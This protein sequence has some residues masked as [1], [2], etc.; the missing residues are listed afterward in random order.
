MRSGQSAFLQDNNVL[1]VYC[2]WGGPWTSLAPRLHTEN[3]AILV[4]LQATLNLILQ[5]VRSYHLS[6]PLIFVLI[7]ISSLFLP[8]VM[9]S[10]HIIKINIIVLFPIITPHILTFPPNL[11]ILKYVQKKVPGLRQ[12]NPHFPLDI[13]S[14]SSP[15]FSLASSILGL[16]SCH[17][18]HCFH[19]KALGMQYNAALEHD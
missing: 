16:S 9:N 2:F 5:V 10:W 7:F 11:H 6:H 19:K 3:L 15:S 18:L 8:L 4:F 1:L 17:F 14:Q 12:F 13:S